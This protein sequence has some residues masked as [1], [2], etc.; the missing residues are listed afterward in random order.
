L[1]ATLHI[2]NTGPTNG[3]QYEIRVPLAHLGRGAHNDVAINDDSIS[4]SHAKIQCR[5]GRW[6][7][8]DLDSTNG[9][10][11]GGVRFTGERRLHGIVDLRFGNVKL[12]FR[13]TGIL[14]ETPKET[15]AIASVDRPKLNNTTSIPAHVAASTPTTTSHPPQGVPAWVWVAV[16]FAMVAVAVFFLLNR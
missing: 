7:V 12:S 6:F 15:R 1:L 14:I 5:D 3:R 13:P 8:T 4:D 16:M 2:S 10:Y 9:S 11:V